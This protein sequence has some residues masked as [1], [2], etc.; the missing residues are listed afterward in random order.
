MILQTKTRN[1]MR[2]LTLTIFLVL[3]SPIF[4]SAQ[5]R[6]FTKKHCRPALSPY[7]HNGQMNSAILFPG[8]KADIMLTFYSGQKYRLLI[9]GDE[10]L[11]EVTYRL[12]DV[13]RNEIY[14]SKGKGKNEFDFKV[15]STQK[16]IVEVNVPDSKTT[17]DMDYQGCVSI[18][19][20]FSDA[21]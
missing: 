18:L 9:C 14:N 17:H 19:V 20:G 2:F 4:V 8:D 11:G 1:K 16:L 21:P 12:L 15:A 10:Q 6:G 3:L 7:V 13:D 5:C